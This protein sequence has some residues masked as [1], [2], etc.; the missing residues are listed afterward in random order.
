MMALGD[1]LPIVVVLSTQTKASFPL[2]CASN[3]KTGADVPNPY[4]KQRLLMYDVA[5]KCT[6]SVARPAEEVLRIREKNG[7]NCWQNEA[8]QQICLRTV[9]KAAYMVTRA[10][11]IGLRDATTQFFHMSRRSWTQK[12]ATI[13][14]SGQK[15][16]QKDV[17]NKP[18]DLTDI[19]S[20]GWLHAA[21]V[22][23]EE[24]TV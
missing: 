5:R 3:D 10:P 24:G 12:T 21:W 11:T 8:A 4:W 9:I 16:E 17:G 18:K 14:L 2:N 13:R 15:R 19:Y 1:G 6:Y 20:G 23:L 22:A 7:I